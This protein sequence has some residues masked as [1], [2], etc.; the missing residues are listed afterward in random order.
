MASFLYNRMKIKNIFNEKP[1]KKR[2]YILSLQEKAV[3]LC[4]VTR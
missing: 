1:F 2:S 4:P 3:I